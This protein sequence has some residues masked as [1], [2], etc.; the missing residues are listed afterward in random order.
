[1]PRR[2]AVVLA[3]LFVFLAFPAPALAQVTPSGRI[4]EVRVEGTRTYSDIVRTIITTR[5]GTEAASVDLEAERNRVYSLGTFESVSVEIEQPAG[6]GPVLVVRVVENPR[7]G[8]VE[9]DGVV[10]LSQDGLREVLSSTHLLGP[11][12]V[13]NTIRATEARDTIRQAYR[14]A[15]FPFDVEVNLEVMPAPDLAESADAIPVRLTYVVDESAGIDEVRFTGNTVLSASELGQIFSNVEQQGEFD[16]NL[17]RQAVQAVGNRYT[18]LGYRGSGVDVAATNLA[19]GVLEVA[20]RELTIASIDT[21][22]LGVD[23]A[24]LSLQ[25]GD[26]FNYDTLVED[27]RRLARGRSSDIQLDAGVT[28]SGGVR[29]T[30]RLGAPETAGPVKRIVFEGNTVLSDEELLAVMRTELGDNFASAVA[31]EDFRR[32]LRLYQEAG[33]RILTA[34][35]FSYDDGTYIQR[36]TELKVAGYEV[37]YDGRVGGTQ[38]TVITRYLPDV[39]E[40][41]NDERIVRGLLSVARLGVVDVVNYGLEPT[42]E[43]DQVLVR[44]TVRDRSTGE[45]RPAAQYAT[46]T[47]F[48]ASLAYNE[49]DFLGLAHSV[50]AEVNATSTD[51]GF[52]LGG[53]LS[54]EV[55]WLY[56]DWLD[57]QEV[58]TSVSA[59]LYSVV[60]NNQPLTAGGQTTIPY[61]GLEE[62]EENRVRVGEYTSRSSGFG[63][64]VARPLTPEISMSFGASGSYTQYL[65]EPV[66]V[67]CEIED[68]TV[69]NPRNCFIPESEAIQYLPT[70]G[71]S[72]FTSARVTYDD[73]DDPDFP[74]EGVAAY[75]SLGVGFGNDFLHPDTGDRVTYVYEQATLGVRTY[76]KLADVVPDQVQD[77]NHVFG[78]RLDLGHQ[79]G[80]LYPTSKRFFV[81]QSVDVATL[82]RGYTREDFGLSRS[83]VTSSFEYR[84][85]FQLSTFATQTVIGIAFVDLGWASSVPQFPEYGTPLFASA[86]VGVQL[87]LGFGGVLLPAVRLDYAFSERHPTG[88][89]SFRIGPV[90]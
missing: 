40:V 35:D 29:V 3:T 60:A 48:S 59:S 36:V 69:Q 73:R 21:T 90:F 46:D 58:P 11:G 66:R 72:G 67:A 62:T 32:I 13:Y 38:E 45:L 51:V 25:P 78:V 23:P 56:L 71:L 31:D 42:V 79:F 12:R 27:V 74:T 14:Q 10:S 83:Y 34:P 50:S 43:R 84:Y 89:F 49:R 55:P 61:P 22:A 68:G 4:V 17:Y 53:R 44:V 39:G 75:G 2:L 52:M 15:G 26:L 33:Y 16:P 30:F 82:I 5:V 7:V 37:V 63:F 41:V 6:G 85:D 88:V 86:G 80:S 1:M 8:A 20:V 18:S 76:F 81:G 87:N 70:S 19:G 47:G 54:Y 64:T 77:E 24:D 28:P 9:F 65:L 57:F